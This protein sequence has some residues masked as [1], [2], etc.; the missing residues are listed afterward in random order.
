[1]SAPS[2]DPARDLPEAQPCSATKSELFQA[3]NCSGGGKV[4]CCYCCRYFYELLPARA[5][6]SSLSLQVT[7][8]SKCFNKSL[9]FHLLQEFHSIGTGQNCFYNPLLF[10]KV[11]NSEDN[12]PSIPEGRM[13]SPCRP[14]L[15]FSSSKKGPFFTA[16][17]RVFCAFAPV[18]ICG[19]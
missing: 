19:S 3:E 11:D 15:L 16:F 13:A 14:A 7:G 9:F 6:A 1:M 4:H 18:L 10:R 17:H 5:P 8:S 12:L 2:P